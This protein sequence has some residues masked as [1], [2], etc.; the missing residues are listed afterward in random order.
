MTSNSIILVSENVAIVQSQDSS[1]FNLPTI[2]VQ[3]LPQFY[4]T[5][6]LPIVSSR[7]LIEDQYIDVKLL[8]GSWVESGDE[9][10]HLDEIYKSRLTPSCLLDE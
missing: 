8:F 1:C 3:D 4:A 10:N 2:S 5:V 6:S 9:D 7:P